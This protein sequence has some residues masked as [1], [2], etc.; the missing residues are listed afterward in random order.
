MKNSILPQTDLSLSPTPTDTPGL[1]KRRADFTTLSEALDYAALGDTG[2]N[3]YSSRGELESVHPYS[4]IQ[5]DARAMAQCILAFG[6]PRHARVG[7][8]A[9]MTVEF[10]TAFFAC[11]YAGLLAVP[12]P[13]VTGLG[14]RQGYEEQ[15]NLVISN[16]N[17]RIVLGPEKFHVSLKNA[18]EGLDVFLIGT[19]E[20]LMNGKVSDQGL[21]P[22]SA[23]E[24]SH[25]QFSSG[26]TRNPLGI[27]ISQKAF[28]AN[29]RSVTM[30]GLNL[31][32]GDRVASWLPFY[33]DM[34]LIG[35]FLIPLTTQMS[36]DYIHTDSFARRPLK[37]LEVISRNRCT[38]SY[39][40]TFGYEICTRRATGKEDL[41]LD[42]SCWR[43][44][45]IGGEMVNP[46]TMSNFSEAFKSYGFK[47]EAF[48][49][50]YGL[51]EMTLAFSF[52]PLDTGVIVDSVCKAALIDEHVAKPAG[53]LDVSERRD[54]ASCG[55]AM[56]GYDLEIRDEDGNVL[57]ERDV[58]F[59]YISGPALMG[60]YFENEE[61][62]KAVM[63]GDGW[64]NTGDMG[65]MIGDQLVVTGR[66][67]DL[68]IINGRNIWPQDLEWHVEEKIE[69]VR[70][71]DTAA[72]AIE[73]D[74]GNEKAY[75][76]I[77][78]RS[79]DIDAQNELRKKAK[80]V[81]TQAAS[82]DCQ[83]V[84]VPPGSLPFTTSGKLSRARAKKN[85]LN[86]QIEAI[87]F[88]V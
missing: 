60:G 85:F 33:H 82:I 4:E 14:G 80:S 51:A 64:L 3:F 13:V 38:V 74:K 34:G 52:T 9:D 50:S 87:V 11:Q 41:D 44:A 43:A 66:Q 19:N 63:K 28:A 76:L 84:L 31:D 26:S 39:S 23:E 27:I 68:I 1:D 16:A 47:P 83:I 71:R 61:A 48:V 56:P 20:D 65:Y 79:R 37:W 8:V 72:F 5:K 62:T 40:P 29:A 21:E 25:I 12:L 57:N 32:I 67:K 73:D 15:L 88:N 49:P 22:L 6:L 81:I 70:P 35:F 42:L 54:F 53:D 77:Q 2:V 10:I 30:H 45:G 36:I 7:I 75:M 24:P 18:C 55:T 78:C 17:A 86:G 59:V 69:M 58:G 46:E